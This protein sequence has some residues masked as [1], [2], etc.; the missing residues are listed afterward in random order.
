[1]DQLNCSG[2]ELAQRRIQS[3]QRRQTTGWI[4]RLA[5]NDRKNLPWQKPAKSGRGFMEN[6]LKHRAASGGRCIFVQRSIKGEDHLPAR[7]SV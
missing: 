5:Q 3:D 2:L 1:V 4:L 6:A 7:Y